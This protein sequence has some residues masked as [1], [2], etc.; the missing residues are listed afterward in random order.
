MSRQ[1]LVDN[2]YF[3][4]Y[5]LVPSGQYEE[6][7]KCA[8]EKRVPKKKHE[9]EIQ[10]GGGVFDAM[11]FENLDHDLK[12]LGHAK[13]SVIVFKIQQLRDIQR[14]IN[15]IKKGLLDKDNLPYGITLDYLIKMKREILEQYGNSIANSGIPPAKLAAAEKVQQALDTLETD[16]KQGVN[17][18]HEI[19]NNAAANFASPPSLLGPVTPAR[20]ALPS[21]APPVPPLRSPLD[22][23][24]PR[25]SP[26]P[27]TDQEMAAA[28]LS[29]AIRNARSSS[30]SPVIQR[31]LKKIQLDQ[32]DE[33]EGEE[34]SFDDYA[35]PGPSQKR[36]TTA[37]SLRPFPKKRS[38]QTGTG[39]ILELP[40]DSQEGIVRPLFK[41]K[42]HPVK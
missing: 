29:E 39:S 1:T 36:V 4:E 35:E 32:I 22:Q 30:N 11:E 5:T 40:E 20:V 19:K 18:L 37:Y 41:K 15:S 13:N 42:W 28:R 2:P 26:R 16:V 23:S 27:L 12:M 17:A 24:T 7:E 21:Q 25:R 33:D 31:I 34:E 10:T 3:R 14:L 8:E 9:L 6:L 38:T